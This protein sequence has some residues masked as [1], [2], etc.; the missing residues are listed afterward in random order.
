MND[1]VNA[2]RISYQ[3]NEG[4]KG[5]PRHHTLLQRC[6]RTKAAPFVEKLEHYNTKIKYVALQSYNNQNLQTSKIPKSLR[7][8]G[9]PPAKYTVKDQIAAMVTSYGHIRLRRSRFHSLILGMQAWG[10][11]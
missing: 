7:N 6:I 1:R 5:N 3:R 4:V 11:I 2:S 10:S 9:V 8:R